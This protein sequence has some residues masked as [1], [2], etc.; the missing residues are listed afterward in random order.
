MR[1]STQTQSSTSGDEA[2]SVNRGQRSTT[3][4]RLR[5]WT[6]YLTYIALLVGGGLWIYGFIRS[7]GMGSQVSKDAQIWMSFYPEVFRSG[8][9]LFS[10]ADG[11]HVDVLLLGGS[12]LE[13]VSS[14]FQT[15]LR[16]RLGDR[17]RVFNLA[18]SAHTS[19]DSLLKYRLLREKA[20]DL[21]VLYDGINDV[22]MNRCSPG[23][24]REDYTHCS[25]YRSIQNRLRSGTMTLSSIVADDLRRLIPLAESDDAT[26]DL[27]TEVLTPPAFHKNIAEI[28]VGCRSAKIPV[29]ITTF[30]YHLPP[31]YTRER[32]DRGE[33]D[34]GAGR[35]RLATELWGRP[36]NVVATL[37][38]QN[39]RVRELAA[40]H[41]EV[42][43]WDAHASIGN[44]AKYFS[45]VCHLTPEGCREFSSR[46][47]DTLSDWIT[48]KKLG[49]QNPVK[50]ATN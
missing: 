31:D 3:Q 14:Y 28:L 23:A 43:F 12:V 44:Q 36:A 20:F 10:P 50:G 45:D 7:S 33:L 42:L 30:A 25:W 8:G 4:R 15:D 35:Y 27:G 47:I 11:D 22:R 41:S 5:F 18:K 38:A 40:E 16:S 34:Y 2:S 6:V 49:N 24:F 26:L 37:D 48:T 29:L 9:P 1:H 17:V 46:M 19:R 21:I 39:D 32:F 13:E